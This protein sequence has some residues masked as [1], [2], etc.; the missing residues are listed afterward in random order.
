VLTESAA[1]QDTQW[2]MLHALFSGFTRG[3]GAGSDANGKERL[4]QL[5]KTYIEAGGKNAA[6]AAEWLAVVR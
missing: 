4:K 2:L 6:L 5:A 3:Q 1:D